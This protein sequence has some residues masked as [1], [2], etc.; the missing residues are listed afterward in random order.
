MA[1]QDDPADEIHSSSPSVAEP[2]EKSGE[3]TAIRRY[4]SIRLDAQ[5]TEE[6]TRIARAISRQWSAIAESRQGR[7]TRM[8]TVTGI[9]E[10]S[11]VFDPNHPEFDLYKW[12]KHNLHGM[13]EKGIKLRR[14]GIT[15]RDLHVSGSG[16]SLNLQQTVLSSLTGLFRLGEVFRSRNAPERKILRNFDG[17][18]KSGELLVVLGRPGSGCST[19]LKTLCGEMYGLKTGEDSMIHYN[20]IPQE[21]MLK[22]FKGEVVY[23]QEVDKH[24]PHLTVGET[25]EFAAACRAPHDRLWGFSRKEYAVHMRDVVLAIFGLSHTINTK[26]GNDFVRGVSGGERKRVSIAEMALSGS[27]IACWDNSTRG[28]DAAT[29]LEFVRALRTSADLVGS[30]HA[31]AIYQASQDIYDQFDKTVVLYEG[32]EIF[33]GLAWKAKQYFEDMGWFCP[34]RQTT[35]DFLTSVTNPLE[36]RVREGFEAKVPRTADEFE[37]NWRSSPNYAALLKEIDQHESEYPI[38]GPVIDEFRESRRQQ[39]SDHVRPDSS[40]TVSIP[41]QI[42][43]CVIRAYQRLWNDKVSTLTTINGQIILALIIGSIFYGTPNNSQSFFSKGSVLF[44]ATLLNALIS[45]S[46][47]NQL[48]DQRPIV[49]KQASYASVH[50]QF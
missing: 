38:G 33:Y 29:A 50:R 8:E 42:R 1:S 13:D 9:P 28:L 32:R 25:L 30:C 47:I 10:D 5:E 20:G 40:Y 14:A 12:V 15:F 7:L 41:M 24:F 45:L 36:R 2:D 48:Y 46:E 3:S 4:E 37:K 43:L 6:L 16:A 17:V 18:L 11:P 44:F 26:V 23:N 49:E 35:G 31:V 39:Q 34:Q 21:R 19:F 22:S 27:P